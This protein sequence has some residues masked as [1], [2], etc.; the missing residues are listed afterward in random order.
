[1]ASSTMSLFIKRDSP[2]SAA[3]GKLIRL[4]KE[5]AKHLRAAR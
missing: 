3:A 1:M 4:I 2:A 5:E